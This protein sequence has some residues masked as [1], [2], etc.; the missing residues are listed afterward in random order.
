METIGREGGS[1]KKLITNQQFMHAVEYNDDLLIE[2]LLWLPVISLVLLNSVCKCWL[3]LI[4]NPSFSLRRN[5][6]PTFDPP[7]GLLLRAHLSK[8]YDFLSLDTRVPYKQSALKT[9]FTFRSELHNVDMLKSSNGLLICCGGIKN[10]KYYVYNLC[11]DF[12]K[13]LP[14]CS[15]EIIRHTQ[16]AFDPTKSSYYKVIQTKSVFDD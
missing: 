12:F 2:I 8:T 5:Q 16:I 4:S 3:S 9:P 10:D 14:Q 13:M 11:T 6:I 15:N 7:C 1:S